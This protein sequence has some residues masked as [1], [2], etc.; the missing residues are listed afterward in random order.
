MVRKLVNDVVV[1]IN[2]TYL[3]KAEKLILESM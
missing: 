2:M 3:N 1:W